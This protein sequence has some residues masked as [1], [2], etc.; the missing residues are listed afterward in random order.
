M[1][2]SPF[3][4]RELRLHVLHSAPDGVPASRADQVDVMVTGRSTDG[5]EAQRFC[6]QHAWASLPDHR[7]AE[8]D[9]CPHCALANDPASVRGLLRFLELQRRLA[10]GE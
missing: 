10:S 9:H 4:L 8:L 6:V 7:L 1:A 2:A 3:Q 5:P